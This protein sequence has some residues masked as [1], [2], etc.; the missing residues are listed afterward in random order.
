MGYTLSRAD[1]TIHQGTTVVEFNR[2]WSYVQ[3]WVWAALAVWGREQVAAG[4][5]VE[6]VNGDRAAYAWR[7]GL[8]DYFAFAPGSLPHEH[9]ETGRFIALRSIANSADLSGLLADI[10]P[11]L[12]LAEKPEEAKAVQYAVSEMVR[13]T[14]EHSFAPNGA[15]MC[16]QLYPGR[17]ATSR[18]YVSIGVADAGQGVRRS[19]SLN[20]PEL[21]SDREAVSR[22]RSNPV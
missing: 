9:E 22:P 11:L 20:Y 5:T 6:V 10:V 13:N 17:T 14:L 16:A 8:H 18:R 3:P 4:G 15:V 2:S 19:L 21:T 7:F 1:W 12:H